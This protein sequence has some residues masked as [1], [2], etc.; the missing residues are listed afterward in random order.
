MITSW[1][2]F[3]MVERLARNTSHMQWPFRLRPGPVR[4]LI[5]MQAWIL[6]AI[7]TFMRYVRHADRPTSGTAFE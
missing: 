1:F 7:R 5:D 3:V 2:Q 4:I 6:A